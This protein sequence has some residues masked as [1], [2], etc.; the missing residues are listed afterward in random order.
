MEEMA[1][2][3]AALG[4]S[5]SINLRQSTAVSSAVALGWFHPTVLLPDDWR[6]W[7]RRQRR[8]VLA[9]ELAHISR[10][11]YLSRLLAQIC[12]ALH[13]YHPLLWRLVARLRLEHELAADALAAPLAGGAR[14]YLE[15]LAAMAVHSTDRLAGWP[16]RS[17]LPT[18]GMLLWR[19]EM[20]RSSSLVRGRRL[21][22]KSLASAVVLA[23]VVAAV[24]IRT[25]TVEM[26]TVLAGQ[27]TDDPPPGSSLAAFIPADA[28]L[29]VQVRPELLARQPA[30][31]QLLSET[32]PFRGMK[33]V[34]EILQFEEVALVQRPGA[35]LPGFSGMTLLRAKTPAALSKIRERLTA[36][37]ELRMAG[38]K[39]YYAGRPTAIGEGQLVEAAYMPDDRTLVVDSEARIRHLLARNAGTT[40]LSGDVAP[41]I[42]DAA[43]FVVM[44]WKAATGPAAAGEG[45]G[46]AIANLPQPFRGTLSPLWNHADRA[47]IAFQAGTSIRGRLCIRAAD[48]TASPKIKQTLDASIVMLRNLME[49]AVREGVGN[50]T[51]GISGEWA[52]FMASVLNNV[53]AHSDGPWTEVS[54]EASDPT[55]LADAVVKAQDAARWSQSANNLKQ[56]ALAMHNF[57]V[58]HGR[59]P[60]PV[61]LGKDGKGGPPHSWRVE[62]LPYLDQDELYRAYRFEEPWDSEANRKVLEKMPA[63]YRSPHDAPDSLNSS[64]FVF[65]GPET[66]FHD[67]AG[68]DFTHILDGV[69]NSIMLAE[70]RR[71]IPWTKP[72][73]ISYSS[74]KPLPKLGGWRDGRFEIGMFD[75]S[76]RL[77]SESTPQ[78]VLRALITI[79]GGEAIGSF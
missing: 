61:I 37:S 79:K 19:I 13:F 27:T 38:G 23:G 57:H 16:A 8:A 47:V 6:T 50:E 10:S 18:R 20:L 24:G 12:L 48:E 42:A 35:A 75:G 56:I 29:V 17:F 46:P 4:L 74:E 21:A 26:E 76:V 58:T 41:R 25:P 52:R 66:G 49:S 64:V 53:Q 59:L 78:S 7:S 5:A 44:D 73:D 55:I 28:S 1:D 9:H 15:V 70:S 63:V 62:L 54:L 51:G 43:L 72:D 67:Q 39:T 40:L 11:D 32:E 36:D 34:L 30:A 60:A 68:V 65:T 71:D 2:V 31:F 77:M 45:F 3:A 33:E 22:A 69:S 14:A